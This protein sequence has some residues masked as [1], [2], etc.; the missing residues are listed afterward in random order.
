MAAQQRRSQEKEVEIRET[1]MGKQLEKGGLG[2]DHRK[3]SG[4]R[5]MVKQSAKTEG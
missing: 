2:T 3:E 5:G 4:N 1:G